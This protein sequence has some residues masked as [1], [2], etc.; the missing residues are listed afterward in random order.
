MYTGK[1]AV[2]RGG[3]G[4]KSQRW[5]NRRN[6]E[7]TGGRESVK[8]NMS[9]DIHTLFVKNPESILY[10]KKG[11]VKNEVQTNRKGRRKPLVNNSGGARKE[12]G[13]KETYGQIK[14]AI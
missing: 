12:E 4:R 11:M 2:L 8:G 6:Q 9:G 3:G 1:E 13:K 14:Y 7:G 10:Q 5:I